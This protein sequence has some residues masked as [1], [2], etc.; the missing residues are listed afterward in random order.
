MTDYSSASGG[1]TR[2]LSGVEVHGSTMMGFAQ[3]C[4][5]LNIVA[6]SEASRLISGI[7]IDRWYPFTQLQEIERTVMKSYK[8]VGPI[9]TKVGMTMMYGWYHFG[10]G[11]ELIKGGASFLHFQTG[12]GGYASV[13]KGPPDL[14]G[15]FDIEY[16]DKRRGRAVI[17]T[18]TPFNKDLERGVLIGGLSSPGDLDYVDV[19]IGEDPHFLV[20]E[21]H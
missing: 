17:H 20:C 9:L 16:F 11:R 4:V 8:N 1:D 19:V 2:D 10:P 7:Q 6:G 15:T 13:I 5:N 18:T 21:F 3:A 14:V 12:S